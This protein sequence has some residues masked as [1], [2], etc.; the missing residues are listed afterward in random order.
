MADTR[1]RL[2]RTC[3]LAVASTMALL[4]TPGCKDEP[5]PASDDTSSSDGSEDPTD[6]ETTGEPL[7]D[8]GTGPTPNPD[9]PR[10]WV[11]PEHK[12][13]VLDRIEREPYISVLAALHERI[14]KPPE[15]RPDPAVW[16]LDT[17]LH[18]ASIV[19]GAA[20]LAW[21]QEDDG[22]AQIAIDLLERFEA[23]LD[24]A[25]I[26]D[27]NIRMLHITYA[28]TD[29]I[30]LLLGA[31]YIDE[32]QAEVYAQEMIDLAAQ[33]HEMFVVND[34]ARMLYMTPSQN[35]HPIRT[36]LAMAYVAN[37]YPEQTA[38]AQW[39]HWCLSELDY[40][41]GPTGHYMSADGAVS[42]GPD[43]HQFG[44][45]AS[46]MFYLTMRMTDNEP[47]LV[48]RDC[49]NRNDADPWTDHGCVQDEEFVFTNALDYPP[50]VAGFDWQLALRLPSGYRPPFEDGRLRTFPGWAMQ[51]SEGSGGG[52]YLWAWL[53]NA[54]GD[55]PMTR[56][57]ETIAQHL[58]HVDDSV[59]PVEPE[60]E[61]RFF[62]EGGTAILRSGWDPDA[63]WLLFLAEHGDVRKTLH[64]HVDSL[65]FQIAAYGEYLIIDPGYYKPS[66]LNNAT[67]AD[68]WAHNLLLIDGRTAPDKGI[69]EDFGDADA[70]FGETHDGERLDYAEAW[71]EYQDTRVDRAVAMIDER[72]FIVADEL[73][74]TA[75]DVREH[76]FRV[77]G[78]AGFDSGGSFG[79]IP[80]GG[81]WERALAGVDV[82]MASTAPGLS[83]REPVY[84]ENEVPHVHEITS[85]HGHHAVLDAVVDE[86]APG[87]LA[88]LA[89]YRVAAAVDE[90]DA[91]LQVEA[92]D[93]GVGA[94]AWLVSGAGFVD[95]VL[96]REPD[97]PGP[98]ML[99]DNRLVT[100]D[101]RLVVWRMDGA[102]LVL[103][104]R[105]TS[106]EVDAATILDG[107]DPDGITV[108]EGN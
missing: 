35:N 94:A 64:D 101:A 90:L 79:Q 100:T 43:Y 16:H 53:N 60:F 51:T 40:L 29:A 52:E 49:I 50:F 9:Y 105:G 5:S 57:L 61:T 38:E 86:L 42:E 41:L 54:D 70:F 63:R 104:S 89:P 87:F 25:P 75:L 55:L 22:Y 56:G 98:F 77:N 95:L 108:W 30:D 3:A 92:I 6:S 8:M 12:A 21:L 13:I 97:T 103:L 107:G 7:E 28:Y 17:E 76:A 2:A 83:L 33:I 39:R 34:I 15:E 99:P 74:T 62:D 4:L 26:S 48:R 37:A 106:L 36:A 68:S 32:A 66:A 65:S 67:T 69:F 59:P 27:S 10:L 85:G 19:R 91:P 72:Y 18:N 78:W 24:T 11:H 93:V 96:S 82:Y 31:G 46:Y 14:D 20:F 1:P 88:V 102:E 71:Q 58:V 47:M 44:F 80:G 23:D 45:A 84:V 73:T 81:R